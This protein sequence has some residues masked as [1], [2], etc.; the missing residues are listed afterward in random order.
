MTGR[1]RI[2]TSIA[3]VAAWGALYAVLSF[4]DSTYQLFDSSITLFGILITVLT[5]FACIE[6]TVLMIPSG[7]LSIGLYAAML[8]ES[9]EQV[10]YLI[11]SIYS[12]LC[13]CVSVR[14]ARRI[15]RTQA[16]EKKKVSIQ[17]G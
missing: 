2:F 14:Q 4:T 7:L 16:E 17:K 3:F 5:Y 9:P 10:P 13:V 8:R 1:Q 12:F 6:Y 15:Y 11:Y